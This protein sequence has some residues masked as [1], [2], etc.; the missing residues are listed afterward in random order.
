M[1]R[2]PPLNLIRLGAEWIVTNGHLA[3]DGSI[4][5]PQEDPTEEVFG[6]N[7]TPP[8]NLPPGKPYSGR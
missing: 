6:M 5:F 7:G 8:V 1:D 3:A 2:P 4:H